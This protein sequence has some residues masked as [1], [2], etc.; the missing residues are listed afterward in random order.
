MQTK[1]KDAFAAVKKNLESTGQRD[2]LYV[3]GHPIEVFFQPNSLQ[4]F[5]SVGCYS[6]TKHEWLVG[7]ELVD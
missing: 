7:P 6:V 5:M 1:V 2:M 3:A 4:D